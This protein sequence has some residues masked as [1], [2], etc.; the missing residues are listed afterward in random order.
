MFWSKR[1]NQKLEKEKNNKS[2]DVNC[3]V[4][5]NIKTSDSVIISESGD[6]KGNIIAKTAII[7]G[8]VTGDILATKKVTLLSGAE[9][10]GQIITKLLQISEGVHGNMDLKVSK[11]F[12]F[13]EL[14][15]AAF[16][17]D[18]EDD[19]LQITSHSILSEKNKVNSAKKTERAYSIDKDTDDNETEPKHTQNRI[20]SNFAD[21][22]NDSSFW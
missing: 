1:S 5:M 15:E 13:T 8:K 18:N 7:S 20:D 10:N 11:N 17:A 2:I 14:G 16:I 19:F 3:D 22:S 12:N 9:I 4:E 21:T 6:F